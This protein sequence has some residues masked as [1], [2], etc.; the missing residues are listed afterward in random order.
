LMESFDISQNKAKLIARDQTLKFMSN[1]QEEQFNQLGIEYYRW[2]VSGGGIKQGDDDPKKMGE[3]GEHIKSQA[4]NVGDGRV[5]VKH[6][7]VNGLIFKMGE[8]PPVGSKGENLEPGEDFQCR[9]QRIPYMPAVRGEVTMEKTGDKY[10]SY[11]PVKIKQ[12]A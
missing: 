9:C 2:S 10:G 7:E 4:S 5:R 6:G 8:K 1:L 3:K 11:K 12:A